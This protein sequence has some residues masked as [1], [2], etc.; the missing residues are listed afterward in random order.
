[1]HFAGGLDNLICDTRPVLW[2]ALDKGQKVLLEGAQG[3]MLDIDHGTYPYVTSSCT[4][5]ASA[6]QGSGVPIN[7]IVECIAVVKAYATRVGEGPFPTEMRD[8]PAKK[9]RELGHEYGTVTGRPR[10]IGWYDT[11]CFKEM[12]RANGITGVAITRLD[13]LD[14]FPLIGIGVE[15]EG[16]GR[17]IDWIPGWRSWQMGPHGMELAGPSV[18]NCRTADSLPQAAK[19]YCERIVCGYPIQYI[20][21]GPSREETIVL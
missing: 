15:G 20:S 12:A 11:V 16:R 6:A 3:F 1:D 4:G 5:V 10:R 14:D 18:R 9:I 2:D 19:D 17:K 13:I 7:E 8:Y 21:V